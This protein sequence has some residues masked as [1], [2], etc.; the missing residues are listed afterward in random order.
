MRST[1]SDIVIFIEFLQLPKP[2]NHNAQPPPTEPDRF[3]PHT[4]ERQ[5]PA[6]DLDW[7]GIFA[8]PMVLWRSM[9]LDR[10]RAPLAQFLF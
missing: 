3:S 8:Q 4:R 7:T 5:S 9:P 1:A 6:G 2:S 10:T